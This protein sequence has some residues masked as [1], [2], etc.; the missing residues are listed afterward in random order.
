M[1]SLTKSRENKQ[2]QINGVHGTGD[3]LFQKS[4]SQKREF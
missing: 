2:F 1:I 4:R 3:P